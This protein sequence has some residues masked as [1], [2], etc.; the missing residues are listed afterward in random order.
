MLAIL[1]KQETHRHRKIHFKNKF[2]VL[3]GFI[4]QNTYLYSKDCCNSILF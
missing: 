1:Q 3:F 2:L 4:N